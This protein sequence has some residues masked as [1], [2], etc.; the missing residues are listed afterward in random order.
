VA[1]FFAGD[2]S[3]ATAWREAI[4]RASEH[5]VP[6]GAMADVLARQ[7]ER[8]GAPAEARAAA[9][10][11]ADPSTVVIAT[12]Q[13][14]GLFGGPLF[15]LV[16]AATAV[17]LAASVTRQHGVPAVAVFWIDAEDHDWDEVATCHVLDKDLVRHPVT[18]TLDDA[19]ANRPVGAIPLDGIRATL[20]QLAAALPPTEF[21]EDL[22]AALADAYRPTETMAGAF[23]RWLER[24][25]GPQGLVLFDSSDPAAKP[26]ASR[27]FEDELREPGRTVELA[28]AAGGA[29]AARG[30]HAQVEGTP[31][32]VALFS[33]NDERHPIR[34]TEGGY[35]LGRD[36]ARVEDLPAIARSEP[37]RF[38]PNVL[39]RPIVQDTLFPT[40]GYVAGPS[41]LAYLAQLKPVY[42]RFGVPMPLVQPRA[43]LTVLDHA[44]SRFLSRYNV[45]L[46]ALQPQDD[47]SL[48]ALLAAELPASV[49][50]AL[51]EA[52][53]AIDARMAELASGVTAIDRT[54]E[55][56]VR[57]TI[58]RM[59]HD[60][61]TLHG[62]IIQAAKRR[63]ETLRRQ[64]SRARAQAFPDGQPQERAIGMVSFF[65]RYGPAFVDQLL[66][67]LPDDGGA[68][69]LVTL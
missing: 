45:P 42:E 24:W 11:L 18:F 25:L 61:R 33:L 66:S 53:Q 41:E 58:G 50:R 59:Q 1:D 16:K 54:L 47:S 49:E 38:S 26:L 32:S 4:A 35:Q 48:N 64:F 14:A 7:Q 21:T 34:R 46:E 2:P 52:G 55:G 12:G 9:A 40:V 10:R 43:S 22:M 30:Y 15:T 68:H 13:Q 60:L 6:R 36:V 37:G 44:A 23:G 8:R 67:D 69:A 20:D 65:N 19:P 28:S 5:P 17:R 56:A 51:V 29:L 62:K 3:D 63:D 27:I 57:S 31:G 39:L